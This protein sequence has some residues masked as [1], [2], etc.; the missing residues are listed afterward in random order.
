M[1]ALAKKVMDELDRA[2][3]LAS[4]RVPRTPGAYLVGG[5]NVGGG[6]S[7]CMPTLNGD[8]T[9]LV[10]QLPITTEGIVSIDGEE[11]TTTTAEQNMQISAQDDFD[12]FNGIDEIFTTYL[13]PNYMNPN[14]E[15]L[16]FMDGFQPFD[17]DEA[18]QQDA[19]V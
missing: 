8:R 5:A 9:G 11:S 7:P 17:W 1:A 2:P 13:E 10:T 14:L 6:D 3:T 4:F 12:L 15:D 16:S 19:P 18:V